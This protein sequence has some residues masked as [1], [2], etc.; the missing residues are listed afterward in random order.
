MLMPSLH[1]LFQICRD[2]IMHDV[3]LNFSIP[4]AFILDSPFSI[5]T[6]SALLCTVQRDKYC[7]NFGWHKILC[8]LSL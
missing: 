1:L 8:D 7:I 6:L 4:F 2:P 5:E 3:E